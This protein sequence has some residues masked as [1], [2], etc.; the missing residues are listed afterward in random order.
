MVSWRVK[1]R[2][3][4]FLWSEQPNLLLCCCKYRLDPPFP[5]CKGGHTVSPVSQRSVIS[6][7]KLLPSLTKDGSSWGLRKTK[8]RK[9]RNLL[10]RW[11]ARWTANST[12]ARGMAYIRSYLLCCH[13]NDPHLQSHKE[14][15]LLRSK[16]TKWQMA[17]KIKDSQNW[18][19]GLVKWVFFPRNSLRCSV[20]CQIHDYDGLIW[21]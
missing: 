13:R 15:E 5:G 11:M 7:A 18:F 14:I 3:F 19:Y 6:F 2:L 12:S 16:R 4:H 10:R 8:S 21:F 9:E 1:Q 20:T 17:M